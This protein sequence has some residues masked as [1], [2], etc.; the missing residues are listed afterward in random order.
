MGWRL[1]LLLAAVATNPSARACFRVCTPHMSARSLLLT[2]ATHA[3]RP[4][5]WGVVSA[6]YRPVW[7]SNGGPLSA[8]SGSRFVACVNW[9][10]ALL[11]RNRGRSSSLAHRWEIF[12]GGAWR[13]LVIVPDH[14]HIPNYFNQSFSHMD[15]F[16]SLVVSLPLFSSCE[17]SGSGCWGGSN[18]AL[19]RELRSS[20]PSRYSSSRCWEQRLVNIGGG[21]LSFLNSISQ[22]SVT[23]L[24]GS[25]IHLKWNVGMTHAPRRAASF[26]APTPFGTFLLLLS[27]FDLCRRR[28]RNFVV[29]A[30]I[31]I[32]LFRDVRTTGFR[33]RACFFIQVLLESEAP[34]MQN[35]A[36]TVRLK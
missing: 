20:R 2:R 1:H 3:C 16:L 24:G 6:T 27:R 33:R 9:K 34:S 15:S 18:L 36:A 7:G 8:R 4:R 35:E 25:R 12:P 23:G 14:F 22:G 32:D 10:I 11:R 29:P 26:S 28:G 17:V 5:G 13:L 30:L 21:V 31:L 19:F